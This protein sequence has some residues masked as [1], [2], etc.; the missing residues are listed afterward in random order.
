MEVCVCRVMREESPGP[1]DC[2]SFDGQSS[3]SNADTNKLRGKTF[4]A[5]ASPTS[6][7]A[8]VL[9]HQ[10]SIDMAVKVQSGVPCTVAKQNTTGFRQKS[11]LG[12]SNHQSIAEDQQKPAGNVVR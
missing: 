9:P 3:F 11:R 8:P 6:R 5:S 4:A 7:K 1:Q 2:S 12:H 10:T